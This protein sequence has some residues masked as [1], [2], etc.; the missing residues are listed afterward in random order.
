MSCLQL[1]SKHTFM[2][3]RNVLY[4]SFKTPTL[5]NNS[6]KFNFAQRDSCFHVVRCLSNFHAS[7]DRQEK[8]KPLCIKDFDAIG[9]DIDHTLAKYNIPNLFDV[10]F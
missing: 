5:L 10:S 1:L 6:T 8:K 7:M 3:H 2:I 9:F 4:L